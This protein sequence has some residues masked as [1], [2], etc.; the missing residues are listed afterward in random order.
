MIE[1]VR[2]QGGMFGN[3]DS[4]GMFASAI[5]FSLTEGVM[6]YLIMSTKLIVN[7]T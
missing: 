2:L 3:Q 6:F 7:V 5:Y 1:R 4:V